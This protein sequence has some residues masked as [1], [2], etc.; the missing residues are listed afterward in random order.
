[1]QCE[2]PYCPE[3]FLP[4]RKC[5]TLSKSQS[6]Y[7]GDIKTSQS[8]LECIAWEDSADAVSLGY[9]HEKLPIAG[10]IDAFCRNPA[11]NE[12]GRAWCFVAGAAEPWAYCDVPDCQECGT[13]SQKKVDYRGTESVTING[14]TCVNWKDREQELL[15]LNVTIDY[16]GELEEN[17]CRN[18]DGIRDNVWCFVDSDSSEW[19]YCEVPDCT[20]DP[21]MPIPTNDTCGSAKY[22]QAD[23]RGPINVTAT[24][25]TCQRWS[26]QE[27][28][29]HKFKPEDRPMS[30]L[31]DNNSCRNPSGDDS[32]GA[33]CY[34]TD[35]DVQWEYCH[36]PV[37]EA[38]Q[39]Q[40][41][42]NTTCGTLSQKQ[43]DY[44]GTI[45][46]TVG[47]IV[48]QRWDSQEP[49]PHRFP[50]DSLS[51]AGLAE[52]WCRNPDDSARAWCYTSD[53]DVL[54]DYCDVPECDEEET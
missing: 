54:Y 18:V 20:D 25:R 16:L 12:R 49:H 10:L 37:C 50:P 1:M 7:R 9:T 8:G 31:D 47:G 26:S 4:R 41:T 43:K 11:E 40:L 46:I 53:P 27:P 48:C 5:G 52:N 22:H 34:T 38:H 3:P 42:V 45:N 17:F 30:G 13:V 36:V 23:Y 44:R 24:G 39:T 28:H 2:V 32:I 19:Q 33:W 6:D 14:T 51:T 15:D 29:P 21:N 35:E